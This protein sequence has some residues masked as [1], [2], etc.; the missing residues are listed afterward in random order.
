MAAMIP[1]ARHL[2]VAR[3]YELID[4]EGRDDVIVFSETG[5]SRLDGASCRELWSIDLTEADDPISRFDLDFS[6]MVLELAVFI[7]ELMT[8]LGGEALP[9]G[10]SVA[11][12]EVQ[13][14]EPELEP[15]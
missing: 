4:L 1:T 3:G 8:A 5:I 14:K 7:P 11:K 12:P 6:L 10:E 9:D 15:A 13:Q 2:Q